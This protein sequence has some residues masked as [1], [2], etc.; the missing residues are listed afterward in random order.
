MS[1]SPNGAIQK[2][3][4]IREVAYDTGETFAVTER[5]LNAALARITATVAN[6]DPVVLTGFGTFEPRHRSARQGIN[7]RTGEAITIPGAP[8]PGFRAGT[9]FRRA[10][11]E[12][13]GQR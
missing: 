6:D 12:T 8:V 9:A 13:G 11:R 4:L 1:K 10:V 2:R 5:V 7:P 3:A